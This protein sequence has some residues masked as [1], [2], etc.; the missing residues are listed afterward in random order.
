MREHFAFYPPGEEEKKVPFPL[1]NDKKKTAASN[2][3]HSKC[4]HC[5]EI[6]LHLCDFISQTTEDTNDN[7]QNWRKIF[8][9]RDNSI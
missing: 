4:L 7:Q 2:S 3:K 1:W 6:K 5:T 9:V 8:R